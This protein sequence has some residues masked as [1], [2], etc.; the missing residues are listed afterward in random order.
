MAE[1]TL[2]NMNMLY[3]RY[4]DQIEKELHVPLGTLYLTRI[5]EDAGIQVDF[6]D[7]QLNTYDDPFCSDSICDF[8]SDSADLIG[9]SVMANLLPFMI[10]A[11]KKFKDLHPEKT[12]VLGGVGPKAVEH[13]ILKK[14]PWI[15]AIAVGEGEKM[16][17]PMVRSHERHKNFKN[18]PNMIWRSDGGELITNSIAPRISDLD[19][20]PFPAWHKIDLKKY[21]GYGIMSSRGC[22]YPCTFCSVAPIWGHQ[23][24]VRSPANI[25]EE[26]KL[27]HQK[28]DVDL[29]LFQDEYFVTSPQRVMAFCD[30]FEKTDLIVDWKAFGRINLANTQM[31]KKMADNGCIELRFGVESGSNKVLKKTRKGFSSADA[32]SVI[33]EA[34]QIFDRVDAFYV[35]GFPFETIDDFY[36]TV[37]QMISFRMMGA[38]IL[39]SLLSFLPQTDIFTEYGDD[40]QNLTFC[41]DMLP[42]YMLTGHEICMSSQVKMADSHKHIFDFIE[43]NPD[44]FP[45]FF[46]WKP[47]ENV[48]P[49]LKVLKEMGFYPEDKNDRYTSGQESHTSDSCGAHSPR[50][51]QATT[52]KTSR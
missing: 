46:H 24:V 51:G 19:T 13:K 11:L 34:V 15:D 44:I 36:Q 21:D 4:Y 27:L 49:K 20:I 52:A 50:I 16:I 42:E 5:L 9:I 48:L 47:E 40:G 35:W 28:A 30:E 6:R 38:R 2:L 25:I 8:L 10:Y 1:I 12:I 22:P 33:S 7:Y 3:V 18:V 29:F 17:V 26:M 37:F 14:F 31:M 32:V 41:R 39:P 23:A 45:G 43:E